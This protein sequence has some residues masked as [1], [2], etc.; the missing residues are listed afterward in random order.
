MTHAGKKNLFTIL[1]LKAQDLYFSIW[2]FMQFFYLIFSIWYFM[3]FCLIF[4]GP[5]H[6]SVSLQDCNTCLH[7]GKEKVDNISFWNINS[8]YAAIE[9]QLTKNESFQKI[10]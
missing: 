7:I 4:Y 8:T 2:Y 9:I 3:H 10:C 5:I 1:I 6:F